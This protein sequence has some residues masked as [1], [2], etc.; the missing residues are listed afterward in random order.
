MTTGPAAFNT[1][2]PSFLLETSLGF[3]DTTVLVLWSLF[4]SVLSSLHWF[5]LASRL[6]AFVH[7]PR[8]RTAFLSFTLSLGS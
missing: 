3:W 1:V 6:S 7:E 5:L 4:R 8:A 2:D